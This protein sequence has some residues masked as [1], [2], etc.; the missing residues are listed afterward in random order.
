MEEDEEKDKHQLGKRRFRRV[1]EDFNCSEC[2]TLVSGSGYTDHC[3]NCLWGKHVDIMPGDRA[4][5]CKGKLEPIA[6]IYSKNGYT[7]VYK[8]QKC[9]VKKNFKAA[10]NDN[11]ELLFELSSRNSKQ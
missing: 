8:C 11:Q 4:S 5:P 1:V 2:N 7:I 10:Q 6:A 3:P 9:N